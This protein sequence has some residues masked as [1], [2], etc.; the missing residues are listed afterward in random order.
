MDEKKP[1]PMSKRHTFS[2][3]KLIRDKT[4]EKSIRDN[5]ILDY[6]I[7][8]DEEYLKA[9]NDKLIEEA[10]EV[11]ATRDKAELS[12]ELADVLEVV[13]ALAHAHGITLDEIETE[14]QTKLELRGGFAKKIFGKTVSMDETNPKYESYKSRPEDYPEIIRHPSRETT[15]ITKDDHER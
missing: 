4:P 7:Y 14:R 11:L 1:G 5:I 12:A 8:S 13:H 3:Y 10:H 9:L 2:M 15:E 6:S